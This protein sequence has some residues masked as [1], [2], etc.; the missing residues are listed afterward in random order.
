MSYE[1][2]YSDGTSCSLIYNP[3]VEYPGGEAV[4]DPVNAFISTIVIP[5]DAENR[6]R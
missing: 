1:I 2:S 6:Y 4:V 3:G 5:S